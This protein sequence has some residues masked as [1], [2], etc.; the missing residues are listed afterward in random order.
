[1]SKY[2][3]P[4]WHAGHRPVW[5]SVV[6]PLLPSRPIRWLEIGSFEGRS[7]AWTLDNMLRSG[8]ELV[9]VDIFSGAGYESRFDESVCGRATKVKGRSGDYLR[10]ADG[11]F[12]AVYVDGSHDAPDVL[13]DAVLAWQLLEVGGVM[14]FDD[15]L[16]DHPPHMPM[17]VSPRVAIDG[18][19]D[20]FCT[21]LSVLHKSRQVIV[22][23]RR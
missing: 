11:N 6:K 8:D 4:D 23:K 3:K 16:F 2:T 19:L 10:S 18:F 22:R 9:C 20:A 15:Y 12:W 17:R 13:L 21:H 7:A 14:I 1:M 5:L